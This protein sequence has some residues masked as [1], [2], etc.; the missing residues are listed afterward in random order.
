MTVEREEL[1]FRDV[2]LGHLKLEGAYFL[3]HENKQLD[4]T[5]ELNHLPL[6]NFC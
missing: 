2:T 5:L 4:S 6:K 3:G 1:F